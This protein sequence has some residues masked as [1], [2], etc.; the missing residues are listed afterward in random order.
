MSNFRRAIGMALKYRW[1]L[2]GSIVCSLGVA[3]MWGANIGAVYP[4]IEV[5]FHDK[6][7]HDWVDEQIAD[8]KTTNEKA[9][10]SIQELEKAIANPVVVPGET[11]EQQ[12]AALEQAKT[13]LRDSESKIQYY[14]YF[15]PT[16]KN[17]TPDS[18]FMTLV[19]IV[20]FLAVGTA[21]KC[22]FLLGSM[23]L[24]ARVGQRTVLDLQNMFF[25]K[26]LDLDLATIGQN[27]TGDLVGRIRGETAAIGSA[28]TT[29]FGKLLL[30]PLK[31]VVCLTGAAFVNWRLLLLSLIICPMA[32]YLMMRL[33]KSTK[34]A[35]KKSMEESAKLMNRLF[36][37]LTYIRIVKA[38]TMENHERNRFRNISKDVYK[39]GMRIALY[40]AL[41]RLNNEVLGIGIICLS[42]L[43]GGYLVLAKETHLF[44]F[45]QMCDEPMSFGRIML[46]YGFLIG[47]S[48][49]IRKLGDVY[50]MVQSGIVAA[51]R[52]FPLIDRK[53]KIENPEVAKPMPEGVAELVFDQVS[54]SYNP[55]Q[56]TL[57]KV[58]FALKPGECL[59]IVGPNGSGKSTLVNLLPR[60]LDADSGTIMLGGNDIRDFK[61]KDLRKYVGCVTQQT[62]LFDDTVMNNVRY[63]SLN[64]T[65]EEVIEACK[66]AHAHSF[67]ERSLDDGYQTMIG[68]HGGRL[69]GGQRQRISLARAILRNPQLLILDEATS[70][71]DPES[72][73]LIHRALADF[74]RGRTTIMITHRLSTLDL[75]DRIMVLENG[76]IVDIGTHREL[77]ARCPVYQRLRLTEL[78]ECA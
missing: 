77:L 69:S 73:L 15:E 7:L 23:V 1:S 60:F 16:I 29:L 32:A 72:E 52:V 76:Q 55:G 38:F 43:A 59:A 13:D 35:N 68:E 24:V 39:R 75:A 9:A 58:S 14:Q 11:R 50:N 20:V 26:T 6:S 28:I 48:D 10:S 18:A 34:K 63:G 62:M 36:Q 4:F 3:I 22:A 61:L 49:P 65:D 41:F 25:R 44:G 30:E 27:G 51:D 42:I 47:V 66:Q 70:Q 53:S 12:Q 56:N 19:W 67:I 33:S 54:F 8:A 17:Y 21:V 64:A 46:F 5:V 31:M 40:G 78:K 45:I 71:I 74:I 37:A 57:D 2:V